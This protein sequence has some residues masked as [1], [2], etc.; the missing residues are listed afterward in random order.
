M[1]SETWLEIAKSPEILGESPSSVRVRAIE[2]QLKEKVKEVK[3]GLYTDVLLSEKQVRELKLGASE[4]E[5]ANGLGPLPET[6]L[7]EVL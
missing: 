6:A 4:E 1:K 5:V 2:E 3:K 7:L